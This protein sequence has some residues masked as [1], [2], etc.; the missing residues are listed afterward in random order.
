MTKHILSF[1]LI[2]IPLNL[3]GQKS[4]KLSDVDSL[5]NRLDRVHR[6]NLQLKNEKDSIFFEYNKLERAKKKRET[7]LKEEIKKRARIIEERDEKIKSL[8]VEV[9]FYKKKMRD[10]RVLAN[11]EK[12][13]RRKIEKENEKLISRIAILENKIMETNIELA[14]RRKMIKS[15]E[16]SID[17]FTNFMSENNARLLA[18]YKPNW[19]AKRKKKLLI[20]PE[21]NNYIEKAKRIN[22]LR[23]EMVFCLPKDESDEKVISFKFG[24][25]RSKSGKGVEE[26]IPELYLSDFLEKEIGDWNVYRIN[27]SYGTTK[28]NKLKKKL[29]YKYEILVNGEVIKDGA[30]ITK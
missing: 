30:F 14:S 26:I 22:S 18:V 2:L 7:T 11:E 27:E 12:R 28:R 23:F 4:T 5:L 8:I 29:N 24:S 6:K 1:C 19:Y 15:L 21:G 10:Y 17:T 9:E 13:N 16:N 3:L 20:Q 25:I